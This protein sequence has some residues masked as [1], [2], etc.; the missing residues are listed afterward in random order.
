MDAEIHLK[1]DCRHLSSV[2]LVLHSFIGDCALL[3]GTAALKV[4]ICFLLR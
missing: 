2:D 1:Q 3:F 4:D